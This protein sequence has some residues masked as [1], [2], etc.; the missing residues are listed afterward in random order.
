MK[1]SLTSLLLFLL[2]LLCGCVREEVGGNKMAFA[3]REK[4][5]YAPIKNHQLKLEITSKGQLYAGEGGYVT[6]S[7]IN[8]GD[9]K[10]VI[11]E[12]FANESDNI[13]LNCQNWLPGMTTY[14]SNNW[15]RLEVIPK[16]PA[17]RYPLNL[18]PGNR[19][20]VTKQLP[21]VDSLA[22]SR[23]GERRYFIKGE[24]NLKSVRLE[25]RVGTVSV[26]NIADK[27]KKHTQREQS[28]HFG[29]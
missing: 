25:S 4:K 14:D 28:R 6:F 23:G 27:R 5:E 10:V 21:F 22:I 7:L 26:R 3:R 19:I 12:W 11:E 1:K 20:F 2:V 13:I 16:K 8:T 17:W 9:K 18:A 24:L 15:V 29:R